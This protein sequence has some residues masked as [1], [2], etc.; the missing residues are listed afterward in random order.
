M[1][2]G[3]AHDDARG[4]LDA[5][6]ADVPA[7][8]PRGKTP[9]ARI[10]S[11][12]RAIRRQAETDRLVQ[13]VAQELG[14]GAEVSFPGQVALA[15][16]M[17]AAGVRGA[18]AAQA[19]RA[20]LFMVG[21]FVLLADNF[22]HRREGSRTTQELW[23]AVDDPELDDELRAAMSRPA[24]TDDLFDYALDRLLESVLRD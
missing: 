10:A 5:L 12:A 19:V 15:R 20:I 3:D 11:V 16:E 7:I 24:S 21:G 18:R 1:A 22:A 14:R 23:R 8:T 17:E 4:H 6:V 2:V 9:R 13:S